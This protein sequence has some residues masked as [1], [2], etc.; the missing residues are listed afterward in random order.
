M[1]SPNT[2]HQPDVVSTRTTTTPLS[3]EAEHTRPV[4]AARDLEKAPPANEYVVRVQC[5]RAT[6]YAFVLTGT[7]R[8]ISFDEKPRV[9]SHDDALDILGRLPA[10][11]GN[12]V[13]SVE[14]VPP[15]KK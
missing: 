7:E 13:V 2:H 5:S 4:D 12:P 10:G 6:L 11:P 15:R 3:G 14:P 8:F 9:V 1:A